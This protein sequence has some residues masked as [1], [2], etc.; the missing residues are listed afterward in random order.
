MK[1]ID[2][3]INIPNEK[4][5]LVKKIANQEYRKI[6]AIILRAID[7]YLIAKKILKG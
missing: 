5:N 6:T 1:M 3:H 4:Y 7:N 2:I